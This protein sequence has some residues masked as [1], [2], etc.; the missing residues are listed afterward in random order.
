MQDIAAVVFLAISAG[1]IPS[2]WAVGLLLLIPAR[3]LLLMLLQRAGHGELLILYGFVLA[4][5]GAALFEIVGIKGDF[6][7]L[8]LGLLLSGHAKTNELAKAL[9]N[10]KELFLIGFFLD[11]GLTGLPG[12]DMLPVL[13][14][15]LALL[16]VKTAIYFWLAARLRLRTRTATLT[17][18]HL[19]NYSE[20]GL[21][22]GAIAIKHGWLG[23]EW[24]VLIAVALS[25][26]FILSAP[27]NSKADVLYARYRN[28]LRR[29]ESPQRLP[30]DA[31][32]SLAGVKVI[33]LGM[34]RIGT[35]AYDY[36]T[37]TCGDTLMG[38]DSDASIVARHQAEG[39]RVILGDA[40]N[41]DF[42]SRIER[43]SGNIELMLVT[44]SNHRANLDAITL[45]QQKKFRGKIAATAIYPDQ[46]QDLAAI[47]VESYY[48]FA[49]AGS[50][51]AQHAWERFRDTA[52]ALPG[53]ASQSPQTEN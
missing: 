12:L 29:F 37:T 4:L 2:P 50:G 8:A 26:S 35:G 53:A 22:V 32:V 28:W 14:V 31:T 44:L 49:E 10:F 34:G 46:V 36:L 3:R 45:L 42:T 25:C 5:G 38:I 33:I 20:F 19:A 48:V 21:I 52:D 41:P 47:G 18:L 13:L 39:R 15:L 6:G 30:E 11:I 9:L 16:P 43:E 23:N 7:A 40:T 51:F 24:L 17:A 1:K 27:P